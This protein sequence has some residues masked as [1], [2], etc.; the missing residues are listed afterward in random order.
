ML[1]ASLLCN[2]CFAIN[3]ESYTAWQE[4]RIVQTRNTHTPASTAQAAMQTRQALLCTRI[5]PA[6]SWRPSGRLNGCAPVVR[7]HGKG[8]VCEVGERCVR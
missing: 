6:D 8:F 7:V 3:K 5:H 4:P 1:S 2:A